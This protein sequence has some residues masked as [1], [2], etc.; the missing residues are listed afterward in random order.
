MFYVKCQNE[1]AESSGFF[2]CPS[3][4]MTLK[5]ADESRCLLPFSRERGYQMKHQFK[6]HLNH[7]NLPF[8]FLQLFAGEDGGGGG[9]ETFTEEQV[10][11]RIKDATGSAVDKAIKDRFGDLAGMDLKE[12]RAAIALKKK[13]DEDAAAAAKSKH[14]DKDGEDKGIAPEDVEKLLDERLKE[15]EKEQNEKT[16]KRL[17]AAEVKVLANELGFADWED[18]RALADFTSVKESDKGEIEGVKEALEALAK[19]KPHLLKSKQ[20]IGRIGADIGGGAPEDKKKR[21]DDIISLAKNRGTV[22]GQTA[23]DPWNKN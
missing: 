15:R 6:K 2:F 5:T 14:K 12:V 11:A 17:L 8:G 9:G 4:V 18:A 22:G 3:I 1:V 23:Y 21:Q 13:A 20:G 16:F 10:Q 7:T 19:K